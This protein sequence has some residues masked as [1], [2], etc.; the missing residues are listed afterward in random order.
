[1][2]WKVC[3]HQD[4]L[5]GAG[6]VVIS[7]L[8]SKSQFLFQFQWRLLFFIEGL[9]LRETCDLLSGREWYIIKDRCTSSRGVENNMKWGEE[10][11]AHAMPEEPPWLELHVSLSLSLS[12]NIKGEMDRF[13]CFPKRS[14][15]KEG[16]EEWKMKHMECWGRLLKTKQGKQFARGNKEKAKN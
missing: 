12:H 7:E 8:C 10:I 15:S 11:W 4:R 1:M 5:Q 13:L 14:Q 2:I 6:L 16:G 3:T 9:S